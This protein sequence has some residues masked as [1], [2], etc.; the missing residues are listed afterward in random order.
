M[1]ILWL[2]WKD[3]FHPEAGGAEVV[4]REL[5]RRLVEDG[6]EVTLL[7][8][9]YPGALR[10]DHTDGIETIRVG[11]SRY[12]HPFQALAY[13][14]R[15]LRNR[16]DVVIEEV[17]AGAPYFSV[18]L[19][20]RA[21]RYLL[22]HQLA[23]KNWF[24]ET[25]FPLNH[26]GHW[27]LEPVATRLVSLARVP[28]IT[29]SESTR[30]DLA[31]HGLRPHRTHIISEGIEIEPATDLG[32]IQ[33][34]SQPTVLSLGSMRAMK[35]TIDQIKAFEIAKKTIPDLHLKLVG[36]ASG[37]YGR[38]VLDYIQNS[39]AAQDIEYLGRVSRDQKQH[40]MQRCHLILVTSV[41]EGWGLI[42]SEAA[43][44]GTPAVVYDVDG[45]RDSVR[46]N[47]TG[48]TTATTPEALADGIVGLL[49]HPVQYEA[50]R[51]AGWAWSKQLTFDQSYQDLKAVLE[52]T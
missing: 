17:N 19:D 35:R 40:L 26:V 20:R 49:Q 24:F 34:Y 2:T 45:L 11:S 48:L 12:A 38:E 50:L 39:P 36:N 1:K 32:G 6:H 44:Q 31:R 8:S 5:T 9:A 30:L 46:H 43:S 16:Y 15:H 41:K 28:V 29:V 13:Y 18:L 27:L 37:Y 14:V 22:Y 51:S 52:L 23:R 4:C 7:T 3:Q 47:Q 10:H 25:K 42:V 33:K 21:R